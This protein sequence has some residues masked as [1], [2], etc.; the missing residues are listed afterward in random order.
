[1]QTPISQ[2]RDCTITGRLLSAT[3]GCSRRGGRHSETR[4][5]AFPPLSSFA[6]PL[7]LT[8]GQRPHLCP[9]APP[10]A[11][12][13]LPEGLG[14]LSSHGLLFPPKQKAKRAGGRGQ[15]SG[16]RGAGGRGRPGNRP[17]SSAGGRPLGPRWA[18]KRS[19]PAPGQPW[20]R[21][22]GVCLKKR[23]ASCELLAKETVVGAGGAGRRM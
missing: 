22:C 18:G 19:H 11:K 3:A 10:F 23:G 12:G 2:S 13:S 8:C 9:E 17:A 4:P 7:P 1:M 14:M 21:D 16:S 6:P 5:Q 20:E 15:G